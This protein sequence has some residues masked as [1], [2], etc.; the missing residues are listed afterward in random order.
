MAEILQ[1]PRQRKMAQ[2]ALAYAAGAWLLL[3]VLALVA[4]SYEWPHGVMRVAF[5][6]VMLGFAAALVLAWYHGERGEQKVSGTELLIIALLLAVGGGVL[7]RIER[8]ATVV[9]RTPVDATAGAPTDVPAPEPRPASTPALAAPAKSIAVLPFANLSSDKD[10]AYFADGIQSEILTRLSKIGALKVIS[11]TSTAR[12]ASAPEN[13]SEIGRQLGVAHIVEGSVQKIGDSVR[14][15]VQL[16]EAATDAHVWAEIYDR[17][18]V[19]VFGI[20][21]EVATAI[22][23]AL[24]ATLTPAEEQ[25]VAARPTTNAAAYDAYLRGLNFTVR[26][27]DSVVRARDRFAEAVRLDPGFVEA[28]TR[29]AHTQSLLYSNF[30]ERTPAALELMQHAA[31]TVARLRPDSGEAWLALGYYRYR[32]LRDY[33][34]GKAAFEQA[35][36]RR[37]N[38]ADVHGALFFIERRLG[39]VAESLVQ[40]Q[41][42]ERL[43][44]RNPTWPDFK[45]DLLATAKRYPEARAAFDRAIELAPGRVESIAAK[46]RTHHFEGDLESAA[47]LL[48]TLPRPG[49]ADAGIWEVHLDGYWLSR[50]YDLALALCTDLL[51]KAAPERET[52]RRIEINFDVKMHLCIG[53]AHRYQRNEAAATAAYRRAIE[54]AKARSDSTNEF[55]LAGVLANAYA[56]LGDK[57]AAFREAERAVAL[58]QGDQ[59]A[60]RSSRI[61]LALTHARFGDADAAIAMLSALEAEGRGVAPGLLRLDPEW[62]PIRDDPRFRKLS[63]E[64][65]PK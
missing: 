65:G 6:L 42:A 10:N 49:P 52:G 31:E 21:S 44:P 34:A 5:G 1:R 51:A 8:P 41:K 59:L 63:G 55:Y 19:D 2:W 28:W 27:I 9:P 62:D 26:P 43:D 50:R 47:A 40:L 35:L 64:A 24:Q 18:L 48:A 58:N 23:N 3:Q 56:G 60:L 37:P 13:L 14:I 54:I 39:R 22:A 36:A 57:E 46:A 4:A 11:Q 38:D 12:Y 7:W 45:G 53:Q 16:I 15:N 30:V 25:A 29:L 17:K 61:R 20:Q 33:P 32:G